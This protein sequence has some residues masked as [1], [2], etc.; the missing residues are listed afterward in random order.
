VAQCRFVDQVVVHE[1]RHVH[2]LDR[3]ANRDRRL[4]ADR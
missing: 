3:C 2:E 4:G 1:R